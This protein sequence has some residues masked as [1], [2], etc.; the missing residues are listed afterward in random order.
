M[1]TDI[2]K[3]ARREA[4]RLER[5]LEKIPAFRKWKLQVALAGEYEAEVSAA[6]APEPKAIAVEV[7]KAVKSASEQVQRAGI[8]FL[9]EHGK[10]AKAKEIYEAIRDQGLPIKGSDPIATVAAHMSNAKPAVNNKRGEGYG[11]RE[12]NDMPDAPEP[13]EFSLE[14]TH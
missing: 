1:A 3:Q 7:T 10:R 5:E 13:F 6:P 14:V 9:R 11:L 2:A 12:W 4:E 8:A